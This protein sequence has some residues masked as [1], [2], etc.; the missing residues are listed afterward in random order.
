MAGDRAVYVPN[1]V[2][3]VV[4]LLTCIQGVPGLNYDRNAAYP[5]WLFEV[6][7]SPCNEIW[8]WYVILGH[9]RSFHKTVNLISPLIFL[10]F[11]AL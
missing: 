6:P 11:F 9:N 4:S 3:Q 8:R 5:S 10:P 7:L 1:K 2:A